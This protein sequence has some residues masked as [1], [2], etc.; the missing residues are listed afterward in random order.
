MTNG[1]DTVQQKSADILDVY[2]CTPHLIF[3]ECYRGDNNVDT[4]IQHNFD[5]LNLGFDKSLE[6]ELKFY[7]KIIEID[8]IDSIPDD[9]SD[10]MC[11]MNDDPIILHN[12][13]NQTKYLSYIICNKV[14]FLLPHDN[15]RYFH[16]FQKYSMWNIEE[17]LTIK[18]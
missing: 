18:S 4:D 2:Y 16:K 8:D 11:Y 6:L 1:I 3:S 12:L 14:I 10:P 17:A 5:S 9:S 7:P 15:G 13:H